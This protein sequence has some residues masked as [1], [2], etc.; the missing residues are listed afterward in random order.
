MNT[1]LVHIYT[2]KNSKFESEQSVRIQEEEEE[3]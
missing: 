1:L 3:K 2:L